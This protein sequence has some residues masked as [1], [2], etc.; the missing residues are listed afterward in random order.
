MSARIGWPAVIRQA[1]EIAGRRRHDVLIMLLVLLL[2]TLATTA[3]VAWL[4][5]HLTVFAG[6]ALFMYG[7]FYLWRRERTRIRPGQIQPRQA[8]PEEPA[9]TAALPVATLP[10]ADYGQ[11]KEPTDQLPARRADRD[12]LLADP[13]SGPKATQP[14][15]VGDCLLTSSLPVHDKS[16]CSPGEFGPCGFRERCAAT[17]VT[18]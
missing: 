2:G 8:R 18:R 1:G 16:P 17:A 9:A 7:V 3:A 12:S 14:A 10:L 5:E 13:R 4:A 6:V 15:P 11:D